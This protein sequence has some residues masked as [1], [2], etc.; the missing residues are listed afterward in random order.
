MTHPPKTAIIGAGLAG[1]T[2]AR[3][4]ADAGH[5]VTLF[6]KSRGLGGRM[7]T[8]RTGDWRFDHGAIAL[9]PTDAEF[10]DFLHALQRHG[11]AAPWP[12]PWPAASGWVGLPGMSGVVKPLARELDVHGGAAVTGLHSCARG[13]TLSGPA[14]ANGA[15]F[16]RVVLAIPQPQAHALLAPWPT[17]AGQIAAVEM[18]PCWTVM[19]G[20][21]QPLPTELTYTNRVHSPLNGEPLAVIAR[22]TDKPDRPQQ[23]DAWVIQANAHWTETHLEQDPAA[24]IAPLLEAFFAALGCTPVT[25]DVVMAHRWRYAM[26]KSPLGQSHL[27]DADL[28][29]GLC[30]DWCLGDT[31]QAAFDSG[32]QMA[33]ALLAT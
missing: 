16:D 20:F 25:P 14:A 29:I 24:V 1:L 6:D 10:A 5:A 15:V 21:A 31:A 17:L 13:W 19:A 30:G 27:F 9:R 4:L 8:R 7:A 12:S 26:T 28:G 18:S 11:A 33:A 22:D 2:C 3:A 23:G 32:R